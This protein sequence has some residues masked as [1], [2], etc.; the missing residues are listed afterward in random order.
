VASAIKTLEAASSH[1]L[2]YIRQDMPDKTINLPMLLHVYDE[3]AR[4]RSEIL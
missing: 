1:V 4:M 3:S 2:L